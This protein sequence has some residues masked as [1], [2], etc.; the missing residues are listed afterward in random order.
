M[1]HKFQFQYLHS[2]VGTCKY[3]QLQLV[4]NN[5][6]KSSII[7]VRF[8]IFTAVTTENT[9][10]WDGTCGSWVLWLLITANVLS[11]PI[12]VTL[13]IEIR[14]SE[15]SVL[16]RATQRNMPGDGILHSIIRFVVIIWH[17][18]CHQHNN[19]WQI[20]VVFQIWGFHGSDYEECHLYAIRG[21]IPEDG[22]L[23][24]WYSF[25][26]RGFNTTFRS[27]QKNIKT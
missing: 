14:S 12:L 10:F 24:L 2:P 1:Y 16:T 17:T 6:V 23:K 25:K 8:Q 19:L 15:T 4:N 18:F 13:I 20:T 27:Y 11:S 22:I 7:H 21:N 3:G 9:V 26:A 5:G